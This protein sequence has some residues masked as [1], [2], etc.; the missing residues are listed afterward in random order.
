VGIV[1]NAGG[2]AIMAADSL[3]ANGLRLPEL[4]PDLQEEIG[5]KLPEEASTRNP[6]DLIASGGPAEYGHAVSLLL[7]SNEVDAVMVIYVPASPEGADDVA[8][9]LRTCQRD[10]QGDVTLLS[11]FMQ[12]GSAGALAGAEGERSIPSYLFPEAGALALS[13]A[14]AH[15]GWR[16]RDQGKELTLDG[17]SVAAIREIV[18]KAMGRLGGE[19]GWLHPDEVDACLGAAGLRTPRSG[20]AQTAELARTTAGEIGGP[21]VVKVLSDEAVHK[22]DVG[23]VVLG[24]EGD[25]EVGQAYETVTSAVGRHEGVLIQEYVAG[26]HEVLIGMTLDPVFGPLVAFGMGGVFV[27]LL[28][29]VSFRIHPITDTDAVEM[30]TETKGFKLLLGYRNQPRGDVEAVEE[31][32]QRVSALIGAIP[33]MLEMDLNPVKVLTPGEGIYVVDARIRVGSVPPERSPAMRDLPGVA[34]V[35][36]V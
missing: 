20:V 25:D 33:E 8:E 12:E 35:P 28:G 27:E 24:V 4:S 1:T 11:V 30:V 6:I 34:S 13:R 16:R 31:A 19:G 26:G 15:G 7:E 10:Y 18:E 32:L 9:A 22:S 23:G 5:T 21:V 17:D 2:P 29:D 14:V 36:H 3:E